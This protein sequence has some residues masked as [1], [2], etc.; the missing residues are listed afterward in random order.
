MTLTINMLLDIINA[1][2]ICHRKAPAL[3]RCIITELGF[4]V[5]RIYWQIRL[6]ICCDGVYIINPQNGMGETQVYCDQTTDNGGW[7]L[8][9]KGRAN[10]APQDYNN[11]WY[12]QAGDYQLSSQLDPNTSFKFNDTMINSLKTSRIRI[13]YSGMSPIYFS[14]LCEYHHNVTP[15]ELSACTTGYS[16]VDLINI[17]QQAT[18]G[19]CPWHYGITTFSCGGNTDAIVTSHSVGGAAWGSTVGNNADFNFFVR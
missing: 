9:M 15:P 8:V 14:N 7:T 13:D 10:S 5:R 17:S 3:S 16:E 18:S 6:R 1:P 11:L 19:T 12:A 4:C 2:W